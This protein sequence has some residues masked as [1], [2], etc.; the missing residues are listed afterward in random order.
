MFHKTLLRA[1]SQNLDIQDLTSFTAYFFSCTYEFVV[2]DRKIYK[3]M[4][5]KIMTESVLSKYQ[6]THIVI[7]TFCQSIYLDKSYMPFVKNSG[8]DAGT[9]SL[10]A[11]DSINH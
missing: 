2:L 9:K 3:K 5:N 6:G 1:I 8:D 7:D 4:Y 10:E 11:F